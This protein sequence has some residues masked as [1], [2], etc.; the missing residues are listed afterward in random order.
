VVKVA[1]FGDRDLE[2][3]EEFVDKILQENYKN[4][5]AGRFVLLHGGAK[6]PQTVTKNL[7]EKYKLPIIC[8][9]PWHIISKDI[10]F[11]SEL[12][13]YR[14]KQIVENADE[15]IVFVGER[16]DAETA[17]VIKLMKSHPDKVLHTIK[18]Q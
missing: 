4:A 13:F 11:S 17:R 16:D 18:V 2:V 6:G 10:P 7:F 14:N 8:F 5:E 15:V 3:T 1:V 9:R 12:F